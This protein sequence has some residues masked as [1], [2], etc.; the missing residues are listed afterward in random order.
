MIINLK[1]E[2][3]SPVIYKEPSQTV[4][5]AEKIGVN[6]K[7]LPK[8]IAFIMD[9][10][11]RWANSKGK[12]RTFGHRNGVKV[13]KDLVKAFRFL[14]I[15]VMTVYAFSTENWQ[16]SPEEVDFL[17][18]LFEDSIIKQCKE[19]KE[20]GVRVRFIG[21]ID[22]LRPALREKI[23]W[24]EEETKEQNGLILNVAANYGG[25]KEI[26]D[27]VSKIAE[28]IE[29][30]NISKSDINETLFE[31]YLYTSSLPDPDLLIR[32]SG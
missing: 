14:N 10:N 16:R 23:K 29:K 20:N 11:G 17:M 3:I 7:K 32:T 1:D 8:H 22:E 26:I 31:K 6:L 18:Y 28:D 15:P 21:K 27:A 12:K 2:H 9:G 13:V 19:L 5:I 25:R 30:G 4:E 24:I